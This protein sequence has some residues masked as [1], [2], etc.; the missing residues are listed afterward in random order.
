MKLNV[1]EDD[2]GDFSKKIT[3]P[4]GGKRD[5]RTGPTILAKDSNTCL[6]ERR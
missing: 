6:G 2:E 1:R 3:I 5:P 4:T